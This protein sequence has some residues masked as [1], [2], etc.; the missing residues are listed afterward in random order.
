MATKQ[1]KKALVTGGAGFIGSHLTRK[2]LEEGLEIVVLDNLSVGKKENVPKEAELVIGDVLDENTV[3]SVF[4]KEIDIVFHEAAV[5]SIRESVNNFYNDGMTNIMGT[6]NILRASM[7]Y[8]AKKIVYASSMA[9]YS[10]NPNQY[11]VPEN[12]STAPI[13]PYGL[14]KLASENY[15]R[16][17][18][19][20][21]NIDAICLRYFNT[22]G[23]NQTYSP[24]VG[25]ITIFVN[26]LLNEEP[27]AIFGDGNQ[28]RDFV[29]VKDIVQ[30]NVKA[31]Y[32]N[33][34][35]AIFNVGTGVGTTVN[36]IA[37]ILCERINPRIKSI[38]QEAVTGELRYSVADISAINRQTG[39]KPECNLRDYIHTVIDQ[40]R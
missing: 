4:E 18:A 6:L 2:L 29:Y 22:Y 28:V 21:K 7:Q 30:A 12:Y 33:I 11:P 25:V 40:Y 15:L 13:S 34:D 17:M 38:Y 36:E 32:S 5:V 1:Y 16:Y 24:Y 35:F 20:R 31:M 19:E 23:E 27:P 9:V 39:Y 14:S 3:D 26:K 37:A 10:D 8:G